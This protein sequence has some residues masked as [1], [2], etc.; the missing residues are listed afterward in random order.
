MSVYRQ[1][2]FLIDRNA[3]LE[4][5]A[6]PPEDATCRH[7]RTWDWEQSVS[8]L[9]NLLAARPFPRRARRLPYQAPESFP[10]HSTQESANP[11]L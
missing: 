3:G 6:V 9:C 10:D 8:P 1:S 2:V 11:M 7:K 5:P 4:E